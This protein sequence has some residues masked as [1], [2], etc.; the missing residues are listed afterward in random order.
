V[1]A[2]T[3]VRLR[4]EQA[5]Q[6]RTGRCAL[7]QCRQF[8]RRF[9]QP[10]AAQQRLEFSGKARVEP[11]CVSAIGRTA[12]GQPVAGSCCRIVVAAAFTSCLLL[13]ADRCFLFVYVSCVSS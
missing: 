11:A 6:R 3:H 7:H 5:A 1:H 9:T 12:E 8:G 2:V 13:T 10:S 4:V